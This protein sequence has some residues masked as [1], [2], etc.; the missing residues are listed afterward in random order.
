MDTRIKTLMSDTSTR[1][2]AIMHI[3]Q[4]DF[5]CQFSTWQMILKFFIAFGIEIVIEDLCHN[6]TQVLCGL[7]FR[8]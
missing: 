1:F 8:E 6:K 7:Y 5:I 4:I 3:L 2:P